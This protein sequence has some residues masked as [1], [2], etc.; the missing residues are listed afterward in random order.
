MMNKYLVISFIYL[1]GI[2][3]TALAQ[4]SVIWTDSTLTFDY[5]DIDYGPVY[6]H[7]FVFFNNTT[8]TLSIET[9]RVDCGCT[10]PDWENISIPPKTYGSILVTYNPKRHGYFSEKVRVFFRELKKPEILKVS[11]FVFKE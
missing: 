7:E 4:E 5:G 3:H 1:C 10:V 9:I 8:D 6:P 2:Q 11:G